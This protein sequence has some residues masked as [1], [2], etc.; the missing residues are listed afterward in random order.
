M[1][2][3]ARERTRYARQ[4]LLPQL[5]EAGQAR[6]LAARVRAASGADPGA[7]SVASE[8][9]QRAGLRMAAASGERNGGETTGACIVELSGLAPSAVVEVAGEP[10][11]EEA[12]RALLGA[13]AAV[14]ALRAVVE[15]S[16]QPSGAIP[17]LSVALEEA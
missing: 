12:A 3:S 4:L 5:G 10:A 2:L 14:D 9:L 1:T 7:L 15:F 16:G 11:L 13:L 6:L 17:S 8:Y